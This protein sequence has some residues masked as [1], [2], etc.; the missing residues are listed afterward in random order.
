MTY[1]TADN[2]EAQPY[3][4]HRTILGSME[5]FF[6]ILIE[7]YAGAFPVWLAP[8]Q[9]SIIP[10]SDRHLEASEA[11][12]KELNAA[13]VRTEVVA[14]S[15]PMRV[16]IAKAQQSKV[17]YMLVVGDKEIETGTVGVRE[18]TEGDIGAM[19][20]DEFVSRVRSEAV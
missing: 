8:V 17:P 7:H 3:M 10:I 11:F 19:S 1:R 14:D 13:G 9:A 4:L 18:R 15:E 6:G 20:I 16:K 5:R 2:T 12:A